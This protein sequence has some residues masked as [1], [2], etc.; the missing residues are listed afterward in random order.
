[1]KPIFQIETQYVD[2][3]GFHNRMRFWVQWFKGSGFRVERFSVQGFR[4]QRLRVAFLLLI[5]LIGH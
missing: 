2:N 3:T 4:V 5:L 1:M